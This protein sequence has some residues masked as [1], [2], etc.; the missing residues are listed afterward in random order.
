M[1]TIDTNKRMLLNALSQ[2]KRVRGI[3]YEKRRW[4]P[5]EPHFIFP[6]CGYKC[7]L[8][9]HVRYGCVFLQCL[10]RKLKQ[11]DRFLFEASLRYRVS[12]KISRAI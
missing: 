8:K 4:T 3:W 2:H 6:G 12:L 11:E 7:A 5:K 9:N 1:V 10:R